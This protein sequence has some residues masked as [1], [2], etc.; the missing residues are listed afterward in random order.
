MKKWAFKKNS[1]GTIECWRYIDNIDEVKPYW[2]IKQAIKEYGIDKILPIFMND[3]GGYHPADKNSIVAIIESDEKPSLEIRNKYEN[4]IDNPN[5]KCGWISPTCHTY[6][7]DYMGHAGLAE[8]LCEM[9]KYP[10]KVGGIYAPDD[11]LLGLGWI[12]ITSDGRHHYFLDKVNDDQ[13][14]IIDKLSR[15]ARLNK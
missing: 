5:F 7:C 12:K 11:T 8:E 2:Y 14:K 6:S 15:K 4:I 9:F 10:I 3:V 13:I 1:Y